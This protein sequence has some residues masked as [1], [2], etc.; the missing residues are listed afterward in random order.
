MTERML[1]SA[2]DP[3]M[4]LALLADLR[5]AGGRVAA[6]I[7][8]WQELARLA[9]L[10]AANWRRLGHALVS[11]GSPADAVD[12]LERAV[13]IEP[14]NL[15]GLNNLGQ[16][17][18]Q[19]G[20]Y[21]DAIELF[22]RAVA[23][24]P[25]YAIG[26]ANWA[27]AA[28][29]LERLPQALGVT[30]RLL[31]LD[32]SNA[33]ALLKRVRLLS[34]LNRAADAL[35]A[36]EAALA[37]EPDSVE[38]LQYRA[39]ALCQLQRHAEALPCLERALALAP[40]NL[41]GWCN[42]AILQHQLGDHTAAMRCYRQALA[43]DPGHTGA[44]CGLLAGVIPP[45]PR[46]SEESQIAHADFEREIASFEAWIGTREFSEGEAWTLAQQHFFYLSYR[47]ES[48]LSLL[49]RYR[50]AS[51]ARLAPYAPPP[52]RASGPAARFR[53]GVV[54]AQVFDHSV[55][56]A[57][58]RGWLENLDRERF[59]ITLFNLGSRRDPCTELAE[60]CVDR[61]EAQVR[62]LPEWAQAI[63]A[64]ELGAVLFPEVGISRNSL[65]L[66]SL[67]LAPRQ[68]ASWGHPETS[69][70]P[71]IDV[72]LSAEAFEPPE[73]DAH[74]SERLVRLPNLGVYYQPY[75]VA[76]A[77][78]DRAALGIA[79]E[80]PLLICPGTPFKYDPRDD[81]IL[82]EIA[83]RLGACTFAFFTYERP[84]LSER[85]Q[86]RLAQVFAAAGLESERFLKWLPWLPRA[87]FLGLLAQ[88]DVYLDTLGFSGFNTFM[89]AVEMGLPCVSREGR[90]LR[91]RLG[92]GI[93]RQLEL[94]EL[95]ANDAASYVEIAVRL[96][97]DRSYQRD[98]AARMQRAAPQIYADRS[99]V[100]AL[101]RALLA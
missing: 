77:A 26:L 55:F 28:E 44:R 81:A 95:V 11:I 90:Y 29:R 53:L 16:A 50:G 10:D 57:I 48:N 4:A 23:L 75:A 39:A 60:R 8:C 78:C 64:E 3:R 37:R 63:R 69:G 5:S 33:E 98:I 97:A 21:A 18:L 66:A 19:L 20:R 46:S 67:R 49:K 100:A 65:A 101:E 42:C 79:S 86:T 52:P 84:S 15:R 72:F 30:D 9:P 70:L 76:A 56:N 47:E 34:R 41:D 27:L 62:T 68:F 61:C 83:R 17:L 58:T 73:A 31:A 24:K 7:P 14:A 74:Y 32:P 80:R 38:T 92:S 40:K 59:E 35:A 12:P 99:A 45:V 25:D 96:A 6:A 54:S 94:S 13:R 87:E 43:L 51:A 91:G 22:E 71:T 36:T 82:V 89:Q 93:L 85:L 2:L 1:A 88:A